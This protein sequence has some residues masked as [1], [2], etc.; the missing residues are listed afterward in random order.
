[1]TE[2]LTKQWPETVAETA[3]HFPYPET[4][5]IAGAVQQRLHPQPAP[6]PKLR[7]AALA[8]DVDGLA[9]K[10]ILLKTHFPALDVQVRPRR[11]GGRCAPELRE[12][13]LE[14]RAHHARPRG[15]PRRIHVE[16]VQQEDVAARLAIGPEEDRRAGR[17]ADGLLA[18]GS[19]EDDS[20]RRQT[21][22]VGRVNIGIAQRTNGVIALLVRDDQNDVG[23]LP[24]GGIRR[25][26]RLQDRSAPPRRQ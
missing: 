23:L 6:T 22:Q 17:V 26:R 2:D 5:D 19:P 18:V 25:A 10:I 20:P 16:A 11:P 1:M 9:R 14:D 7:W 13:R 3:V 12:V 24:K 21:I 8:A 15:V 4:P